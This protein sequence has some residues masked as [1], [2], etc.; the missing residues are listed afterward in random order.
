MFG[1]PA[2]LLFLLATP[3]LSAQEPSTEKAPTPSKRPAPSPAAPDKEREKVFYRVRIDLVNGE[4]VI[5][6]V[7]EGKTSE[8]PEGMDFAVAPREAEGAG[9]RVWYVF[10]TKSFVFFP[11]DV[12][13]SVTVLKRLSD[14]EVKALDEQAEEEA[15]TLHAIREEKMKR[16]RDLQ[17]AQVE[18]RELMEK[19][20]ELARLEEEAATRRERDAR[21]RGLLDLF[22]PDEGWTPERLV[23]I[24]RRSVLGVYPTPQEREFVRVY[25]EWKPA[26]EAWKRGEVEWPAS[27]PTTEERSGTKEEADGKGRNP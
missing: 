14:L 8:R 26:H 21:F 3:A 11:H 22:P 27:R 18:E 25:E 19:L 2:L 7:R 10:G 20:R 12:V 23:E 24:N 6:H 9:L 1:A 5:G 16:L 15:R 13:K 17:A 4:K